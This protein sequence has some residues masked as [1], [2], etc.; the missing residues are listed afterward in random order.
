MKVLNNELTLLVVLGGLGFGVVVGLG[1]GT[2]SE[3]S[4]Q[5]LPI[6]VIIYV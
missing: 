6:H 1:V 4:S 2:G 5:R 3:P